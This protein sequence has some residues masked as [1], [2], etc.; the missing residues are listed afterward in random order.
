MYYS[1]GDAD[2][3]IVQKV[4]ESATVT[5]TALVGD[6]T[7]LLVLLCYHACLNSHVI[8]FKSEQK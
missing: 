8:F 4:A 3:M 5:D 6:D 7:D 1:P 2:V